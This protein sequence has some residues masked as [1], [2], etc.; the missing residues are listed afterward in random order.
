MPTDKTKY[1][2]NLQPYVVSG[3]TTGRRDLDYYGRNLPNPL[4]RVI[5][6]RR[7]ALDL[8]CGNGRINSITH[9][10]FDKIICIDP[11]DELH[12]KFIFNNIEY[13]KQHLNEITDK[14]D[15]IIMIGSMHSIWRL[16]ERGTID[17][18]YGMLNNDGIV[19]SVSD[20]KHEQ[21]LSTQSDKFE[22]FERFMF[23]DNKTSLDV[24]KKL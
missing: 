19:C 16:H 3:D 21:D 1:N 23:D 14:V 15:V 4:K 10:L 5:G 6:D 18:L 24:F 2:Y 22:R 13:R 11:I 20:L 12:P 7:I 9:T 8:G 17:F